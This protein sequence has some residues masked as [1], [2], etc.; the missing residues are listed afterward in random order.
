MGVFNNLKVRGKL[1]LLLAVILTGMGAIT[2]HSLHKL[3]QVM[4][5]HA[6]AEAQKLA[7]LGAAVLDHYHGLQQQ[8]RY[9]KPEAQR[10]AVD[11]LRAMKFQDTYYWIQDH[12]QVLVMHGGNRDLESRDMREVRDPSGM[13][14]F[15]EIDRVARSEGSGFVAYAWPKPGRDAPQ[16]KLSYVVDFPAW[17]WILGVGFYIDNIDA[18]YQTEHNRILLFNVL[19]LTVLAALLW[20]LG[21]RLTNGATAILGLARRLAAGDFSKTVSLKGRDE[22]GAMAEALDGAV[23]RMRGAFEEL[24]ATAERNHQQVAALQA[25][26]RERKRQAQEIQAASEQMR[27]SAERERHAADTLRQQVDQLLT[28]VERAAQGDLTARVNIRGEDAI[29]RVGTGLGQLLETLRTG[30][31]EIGRNA[32]TLGAAA[33]EFTA[34]S[35]H[36]TQNA[37]STSQQA[38]ALTEAA[39]QVDRN[40]QTVATAT[41]RMSASIQE[42]TQN[43]QQA[44]NQANAAAT[45]A[46]GADTMVAKLAAS[47][48]GIGQVSKVI[49]SIAEQTNLLAL[50]ATI[51]AA[52]AGEAGQ[53]FAVVANEVKDL[54]RGTSRATEDIDRRIEAIQADT[55]DVVAAIH[56]IRHGIQQVNEVATVIADAID[57]QTTVTAEINQNVSQAARSS[58]EIANSALKAAEAARQVKA[59]AADTTA[60]TQEL[61]RMAAHQNELVS[62]FH[63]E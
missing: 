11:T 45:A 8:G 58:A 14:L 47:S 57:V 23:A 24:N 13:P 53:G 28:T 15:Q 61:A 20:L 1:L 3:E 51:E 16:P 60:A 10:L 38:D 52:R 59:A 43:V 34:V 2:L 33:E 37:N 25:A 41:E 30:M 32:M 29:G 9:T 21:R 35:T 63:V 22:F 55:Q 44:V 12:N 26:E 36:L 50:N 56:A 6:R 54:A 42:I 17:G 5:E 40:V 31:K 27:A 46:E 62:H 18:I 4:T 48:S 39:G 49:T 19:L 7:K